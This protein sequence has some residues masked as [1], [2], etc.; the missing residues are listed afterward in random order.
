MLFKF[1]SRSSTDLIITVCEQINIHL[2][3]RGF[4]RSWLGFRWNPTRNLLASQLWRPCRVGER[5]VHPCPPVWRLSLSH[6]PMGGPLKESNFRNTSS[7]KLP[8]EAEPQT[9]EYSRPCK[10]VSW[11]WVCKR[12]SAGFWL[13]PWCPLRGVVS[14]VPLL[15]P[16]NP[17][18]VGLK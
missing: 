2:L 11:V 14:F 13:G 16:N 3:Q 1:V 9:K 17:L 7:G 4:W 10:S 8:G 12:C 18:S 6:P 5:Y 15:A